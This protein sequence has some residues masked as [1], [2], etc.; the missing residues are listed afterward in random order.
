MCFVLIRFGLEFVRMHPDI[1]LAESLPRPQLAVSKASIRA[2]RYTNSL[3]NRVFTHL[4][5]F[6]SCSLISLGNY[7]NTAQR[8]YNIRKLQ[9]YLRQ[10]REGQIQRPIETTK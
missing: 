4:K 6:P 3:L 1:L 10:A 5:I 8:D 7:Q 2:L 9:G